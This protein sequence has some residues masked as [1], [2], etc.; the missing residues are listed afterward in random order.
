MEKNYSEKKVNLH[1]HTAHCRHASGL[2]ED[3]CAAALEQN[4]EILGFSDHAPFPDERCHGSTM[5]VQ[6]LNT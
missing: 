6:E 4:F 1:T 2:P 3:Y 5:C